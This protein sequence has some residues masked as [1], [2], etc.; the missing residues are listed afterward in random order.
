MQFIRP[1]HLE[2]S[3][4]FAN[5]SNLLMAQKELAQINAYKA[6][7]H[8]CRSCV[9]CSKPVASPSCAVPTGQ[10]GMRAALLQGHQQPA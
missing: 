10:A 9:M 7:D 3:Q 8:V 6:S 2:V 1:E 5:D 4:D